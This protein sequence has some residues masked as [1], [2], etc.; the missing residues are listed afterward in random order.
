MFEHMYACP[1][2]NAPIPGGANACPA[3]GVGVPA[4]EETTPHGVVGTNAKRLPESRAGLTWLGGIALIL[5][6]LLIV[7]PANLRDTNARYPFGG[8]QA[9]GFLAGQTFAPIFFC[10]IGV[11]LYYYFRRKTRVPREKK[12]LVFA[13]WAAGMTLLSL[14]GSSRGRTQEND[15]KKVVGS[16]AKEAVGGPASGVADSQWAPVIKRFFVS[17]KARNEEYQKEMAAVSGPELAELYSPSAFRS[18]AKMEKVLSVVQAVQQVEEKYASLEPVVHEFRAKVAQMEENESKRTAF[19]EG[20]EKSWRATQQ[21]RVRV[22]E[23]ES[24]WLKATIELYRFAIENQRHI[25]ADSKTIQ[26]SD[27]AVLARFNERLNK[28]TSLHE[29]TL[30]LQADFE[31]YQKAKLSELGLTPADFSAPESSKPPKQ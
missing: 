7:L 3:C 15:V 23:K 29:E 2:C 4:Q 21:P 12:F 10:G 16:L 28:A 24:Q 9:K 14:G 13:A 26:I 6:S 17:I 31:K 20:F 1:S 27:D 22:L 30:R 19:L 8:A 5:L 18:R 25:R 11:G